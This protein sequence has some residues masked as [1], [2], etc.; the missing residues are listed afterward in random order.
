LFDN[1]EEKLTQGR[2]QDSQSERWKHLD[3]YE[4]KCFKARIKAYDEIVEMIDDVQRISVCYQ[5][6]FEDVKRAKD[7]AFGTGVSQNRFIPDSDMAAAWKRL[8]L[9][10]GNKIDE[11]L[12][13][14]EIFESD[15]VINQGMNQPDAH[16]LAQEI[17]PWS[18]LL[19]E[20]SENQ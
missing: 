10:Q 5:L 15:L 4:Q 14:H 11:V 19:K 13:K 20:Q 7:Y 16:N 8:T 2:G 18:K 3:R 6:S 17:Y 9:G 12:L 1:S